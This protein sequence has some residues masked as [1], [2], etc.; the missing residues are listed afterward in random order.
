MYEVTIKLEDNEKPAKV[1]TETGEVIITNKKLNNIPE[2]KQ[3]QKFEEFNKVNSKAV[4]FLET[5]LSNEELGIVFKMINRADYETNVMLPLNDDSSYREI[6]NEFG[7]NKNK[8]SAIFKKL[9]DLGVYAQVKVANGINSEYW[10]LSPYVAW[11]GKFIEKSI[12]IYFYNTIIGK[13]VI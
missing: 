8:V 10:T 3:I 9:F 13:S 4:R 12:S 2:D 11:K 6:S 7:I 5:V 1:N